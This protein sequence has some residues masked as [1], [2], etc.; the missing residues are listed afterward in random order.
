VDILDGFGEEPPLFVRLGVFQDGEEYEIAIADLPP[1]NAR[2]L[3]E[4]LARAAD[5][6]E[7]KR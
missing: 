6:A 1:E 7:G 5:T 2:K 3:G 4:H